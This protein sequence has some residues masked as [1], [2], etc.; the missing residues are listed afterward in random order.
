MAGPAF[1]ATCDHG[2]VSYI[3]QFGKP[4]QQAASETYDAVLASARSDKTSGTI[5]ETTIAGHR[6]F[7]VARPDGDP[8]GY[9]EFIDF[10]PNRLVTMVA[11]ETDG[12]TKLTGAARATA[13][14]D[15]RR[16]IASLELPGK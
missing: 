10:A 9:G 2:G 3:A 4:P 11:F 14:A 12:A 5:V 6:A 1:I 7:T 16:F 15:T 8:I 13:M